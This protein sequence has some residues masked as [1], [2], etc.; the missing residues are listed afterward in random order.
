MHI[1]RVFLIHKET[2]V[3]NLDDPDWIVV[4]FGGCTQDEVQRQI[5]EAMESVMV[6]KNGPPKIHLDEEN[7]E[8]DVEVVEFDA[9]GV[10]RL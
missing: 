1:W 4:T 3:T 8:L 7:L 2:G 10:A 5:E 9:M 6:S